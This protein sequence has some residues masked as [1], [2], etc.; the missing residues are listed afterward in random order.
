MPPKRL[1]DSDAIARPFLKWA[2]GKSQL[3]EQFESLY[4]SVEG[5]ARDWRFHEPFMG[6]GAV[7][8][9]VRRRLAPARA[10]LTDS[11]AELVQTFQAV[12]D[13]TDKVLK[14]LHE[15][16]ELHGDEHYYEVRARDVKQLAPADLAA[17]M[18]YLNKTCFNGLYRVNSKGQFNVPIGRYA[19][20]SIIDEENLRSVAA[21]LHGLDIAV[22]DFR[23]VR[24]HAKV[25]DFVY[26][27]PP[28]HPVS[29]TAYFTAYTAGDFAE[30]E[31]REL[32]DL[33]AELCLRGC[34]VMLSNSDT[35]LINQLYGPRAMA[36]KGVKGV[37]VRK[38]SATRRINSRADRRGAVSEVVVIN[39]VPAAERSTVPRTTKTRRVA[40]RATP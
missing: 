1:P 13:Q 14:K 11:N 40:G 31:Q 2:G 19:K 36:Q 28:Y 33:Y 9:H 5:L 24:K 4:P 6:S 3:L 35:P 26:F 12:R 34:K 29:D 20:P 38:V 27:D 30:Q 22:G 7:F 21:A 17:R 39:Y 8:F 32:A 15:H 10:R 25:G 16:R 18:I 23:D 37:S